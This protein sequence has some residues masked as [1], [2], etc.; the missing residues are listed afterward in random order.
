M[1][2]TSTLALSIASACVISLGGVLYVKSL[3]TE[4]PLPA[5]G[6]SAAQVTAL[7]ETLGRVEE[8][9]RRLEDRPQVAPA[10]SPRSEVPVTRADI[11]AM[12]REVVAGA[13]GDSIPTLGGDEAV[14]P[15]EFAVDG[16]F[17]ELGSIEWGDRSNAIWNE[18]R[19]AGKTKELL[20][21]FEAAAAAAPNLPQAQYQLGQACIQALM[22]TQDFVEQG[23]LSQTADAAFDRTLELEATHWE[24]RYSK[25]VSYTFWPDFLG[26]KAEAVRHLNVLLDQQERAGPEPKHIEAYLTL[27]NLYS[28]QGKEAEALAVWERGIA[29]FPTDARL[30]EKLGR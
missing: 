18:A 30:L 5:A 3:R 29:R 20:A 28:Q 22:G 12:V 25:A 26:K 1:T 10:V 19:K 7:S 2:P 17:K 13:T 14:E 15:A 9:L 16:A 11:E 21:L 8:R 27:G 24:A 6:A 4:A 23:K